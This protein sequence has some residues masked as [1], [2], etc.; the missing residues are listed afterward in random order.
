LKRAKPSGKAVRRRRT[1][2]RRR[3]RFT[4]FAA[5]L[6]VT[7][8]RGFDPS[9]D[10]RIEKA[11]GGKRLGSGFSFFDGV[12]DMDFGF[13]T[14]RE[15]KRALTSVKRELKNRVSARVVPYAL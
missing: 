1:V 12:R 4:E 2:H 3:R 7:Y 11:V 14:V 15:A 5:R 9:L 10:R 6:V 13:D 8:K